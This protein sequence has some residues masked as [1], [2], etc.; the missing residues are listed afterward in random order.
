[1]VDDMIKE[2]YRQRAG[3]IEGP[4]TLQDLRQMADSGSLS[5]ADL[6]RQGEAGAWMP[7]GTVN[8]AFT[9]RRSSAL[10]DPARDLEPRIGLDAPFSEWGLAALIAGS[11]LLIVTPLSAQA[12]HPIREP[13][14]SRFLSF[15]LV[16][17]LQ[18]LLL[19]GNAAC[20]ACG[21]QGMLGYF[22]Q[23]QRLPLNLAGAAVS[24]LSMVL[25]LIT[26]VALIRAM[27]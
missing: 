3:R 6:V 27:D 2:W 14:N 5:A 8:G 20:V 24:A 4:Y 1:M 21:V 26:A 22:R 12:G 9:E 23:R 11:A 13:G 15:L 18:F 7:F 10:S 17:V 19:L 16:F 25:W